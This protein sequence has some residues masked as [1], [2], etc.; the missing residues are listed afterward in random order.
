MFSGCCI[1]PTGDVERRD[2]GTVGAKFIDDRYGIGDGAAR[3]ATASGTEHSINHDSR[4]RWS[5]RPFKGNGFDGI[6]RR[7][8]FGDR[9]RRLRLRDFDYSHL[10][11]RAR[12]NAGHHP[13]ISAIVAR[14]RED[15]RAVA[16]SLGMAARDLVSGGLT[17]AL[18]QDA[19][20]S[21]S[22]NGQ[23]IALC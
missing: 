19:R 12:E 11:T 21:S 9:I 4:T 2:S 18:H 8:L 20:W 7:F 23:P 17:S 10:Y 5:A 15:S 13:A 14:P 1:Q 22:L 3:L 16:Q 6:A